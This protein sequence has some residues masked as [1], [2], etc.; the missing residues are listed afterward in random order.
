MSNSPDTIQHPGEDVAVDMVSIPV[1]LLQRM[2][3]VVQ[4]FE[5]FQDELE[6]YL[7]SQDSDCLARMR[8][9]RTH[10]LEGETR[11]LDDLKHELCIK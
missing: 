2:S 7:L 6:D 1:S 9:A 5:E 8:Q 4:A 10:H 3:E 11:S